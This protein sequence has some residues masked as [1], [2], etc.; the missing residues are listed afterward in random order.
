[1]MRE[2]DEGVIYTRGD[3]IHQTSVLSFVSLLRRHISFLSTGVWFTRLAHVA[4]CPLAETTTISCSLI[5]RSLH[6]RN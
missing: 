4:L 6:R 5:C 2:R 3:E 1:M